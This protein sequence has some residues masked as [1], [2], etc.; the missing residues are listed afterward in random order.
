MK[1]DDVYAILNRKIKLGGGST[2]DIQNAVNNYLDAHPVQPGATDEQAQQI[3]DNKD[4]IEQLQE[5]L[6]EDMSY[7]DMLGFLFGDSEGGVDDGE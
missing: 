3:Q 6:G 7:E 4:A 1:A 2:A 5:D